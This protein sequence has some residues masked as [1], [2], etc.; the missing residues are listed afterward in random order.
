MKKFNQLSV[1]GLSFLC[2]ILTVTLIVMDNNFN[3]LLESNEELDNLMARQEANYEKSLNNWEK[4][5]NDTLED[6]GKVLAENDKL[7]NSS[8]LPIYTYTKSEIDLLAR[9]VQA[10]AGNY[11]NH[12]NSQQYITQVILN[13]VESAEFPNNITDVIYDKNN[14]TQFSVV[15]NGMLESV[16][17]ESETLA[18]VYS[19]LVHGTDLPSYVLYFYSASV[20]ENWVNTLNTYKTL[21][22]TVFA[23][24]NKEE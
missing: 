5:Y 24:E 18:N 1:L 12:K 19:V 23:Y 16:E 8:I 10:E 3:K 17:L 6:Y 15:Y 9:C 11:A 4:L 14:G 22:G 2:I 20:K 13:R 7:K 21:E